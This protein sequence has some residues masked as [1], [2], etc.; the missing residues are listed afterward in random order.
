MQLHPIQQQYDSSVYR[1]E[2]NEEDA[3]QADVRQPLSEDLKT[4]IQLET[5][6]YAKRLESTEQLEAINLIN[7]SKSNLQSVLLEMRL[8][9]SSTKVEAE[10]PPAALPQAN[11]RSLNDAYYESEND[12]QENYFDDDDVDRYLQ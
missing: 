9:H 12:D 3:K 10:Q 2:S 11:E 8:T 6:K 5:S 1:Y 4:I 7:E